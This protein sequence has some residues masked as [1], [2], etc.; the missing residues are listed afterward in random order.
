MEVVAVVKIVFSLALLGVFGLFIHLF[1]IL[2]LKPE[3]LRAKLRRQGIRGPQP[4]F[5]VGNIPD[6]KKKKKKKTKSIA[7]A[8]SPNDHDY[9]SMF[10]PFFEQWR[11]KYGRNFMFSLGNVQLLYVTDP[12]VAK[13]ISLCTSLDLGKPAYQHKELGALLGQGI[14]TSNGALWAHQRKTIAPQLFMDKVKDMVNLMSEAASLLVKSWDGKIESEGGMADIRADEDLRTFSSYIISKTL[15]GASYTKGTDIFIRL[16]AL[17]N[18]LNLPTKTNREIW[19]LEKEVN[20]MILKI[21]K[22]RTKDSCDQKDLLQMIIEGANSANIGPLTSEQFIIDN[23]KNVYL[24]GYEPTA[25]AALWGLMLLALHPEWQARVRAEVFEVCGDKVPDA[26][27]LR[28]MKML[29]MV[30]QEVLRLY[31][32]SPI[33][34]REALQ[35]MKFGDI[36]IP[37][38]VNVWVSVLDLHQ[39]P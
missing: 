35:E 38:G 26:D 32:S 34:S 23:C 12:Y 29:T 33:M 17:R 27:M 30:I 9:A 28:K 37:K 13:E 5:L 6:M 24:A 31:P 1:D 14:L 11:E 36:H 18:A 20:S 25:I 21:V 2:W 8:K 22:E 3:R 7:A 4:Y 10:F 19:R 39:D 16:R 15:F